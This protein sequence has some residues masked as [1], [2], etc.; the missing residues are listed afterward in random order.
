M[1][2]IKVS[3]TSTL[4]FVATSQITRTQA[5]SVEATEGILRFENSW[6][7]WE[8]NGDETKERFDSPTT[9]RLDSSEKE[10]FPNTRLIGAKLNTGENF[11]FG[12]A[13][14][15][16]ALQL[17]AKERPNATA[18]SGLFANDTG[19]ILLLNPTKTQVL[20]LKVSIDENPVSVWYN[21]DKSER[22]SEKQTK[23]VRDWHGVKDAQ[24]T[25]GT[26]ERIAPPGLG[27]V[28]RPDSGKPEVFDFLNG[29]TPSRGERQRAIP[30]AR[31]IGFKLDDGSEYLFGSEGE[32][33]S[34]SALVTKALAAHPGNKL[35]AR[36]LQGE[37]KA[38]F[39]VPI[40]GQ[41]PVIRI[42][43][44]VK[45]RKIHSWRNRSA[46]ESRK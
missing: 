17:V 20:R 8:P 30:G 28:F 23:W 26:L 1:K 10:R 12:G 7:H 38:K 2:L 16:A 18:V 34:E 6:I 11:Y 24:V 46:I 25:F 21:L 35:S 9:Y 43:I 41:I 31:E 13:I 42:T 14:G 40:S 5:Q 33:T 36:L 29:K 37:D 19:R 15:M 45:N 4:L 27:Y 3:I 22:V 44:A 32:S 39:E